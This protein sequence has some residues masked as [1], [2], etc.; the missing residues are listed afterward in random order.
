MDDTA[1][2]APPIDIPTPAPTVA[3]EPLPEPTTP[4]EVRSETIEGAATPAISATPPPGMY[5]AEVTVDLVPSEPG[6]PIW[7]TINGG[8][9]VVGGSQA[10]SGPVVLPS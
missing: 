4:P 7:F 6:A 10:W 1:P 3:P 8:P 5:G 2:D 9:P